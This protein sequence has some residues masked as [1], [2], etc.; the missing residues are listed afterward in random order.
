MLPTLHTYACASNKNGE[1]KEKK[2]E[3]KRILCPIDIITTL[4][5]WTRI[6]TLLLVPCFIRGQASIA[7]RSHV[8]RTF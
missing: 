5:F 8:I 3:K 4:K 7:L 1:Q 6:I 2:K